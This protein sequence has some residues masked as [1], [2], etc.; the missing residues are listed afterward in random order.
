MRRFA[1]SLD[2]VWML[3]VLAGVWVFVST[4]PIRPHDFWWHIAVGRDILATGRIPEADVFS[5]TANGTPYPAYKTFWLM[6]VTLYSVYHWGGAAGVVFFQSVLITTAY[7]LLLV[8]TYRLTHSGRLAAWSVLAAALTGFGDWNVR[9]QAVTFAL[10][11]ANLLAIHAYRAR[12]HPAW[13][14]VFPLTM[15]VWVNSHGSFFIAFLLAGAW[16]ADEVWTA[17]HDLPAGRWRAPALALALMALALLS[18]PHGLGIF[19]YVLNLSQ[20][21]VVRT[22]AAEW[23]SPDPLSLFGGLFYAVMALTAVT[24]LLSPRRPAVFEVL[25][26]VG[27]GVLGAQTARGMV[28]FGLVAAPALAV[29]WAA[30]WPPQPARSPGSP[31]LNGAL[32]GL[33]LVLSLLALPWFKALWP[34]PPDKAGLIS[35]ETPLAATRF[36]LE[37]PQTQPLFNFS[38][39]GSY[40][41]WEAYPA[42]QVFVDPRFELYP[43]AVWND[44]LAIQSVQPDWETRL[45]NYGV[46]T[47]LLSPVYQPALLQAVRQSPGWREVYADAVAVIVARVQPDPAP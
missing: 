43:V 10:G 30:R 1:P 12:P 45:R 47:L 7:G 35:A 44:Y 42:Y 23:Q 38:D 20:S 4:H 17:R 21:P 46:Q 16:L 2:V 33:W 32:A 27:L 39:F 19:N 34:L 26:V 9:P 6:Q 28:W 24:W 13:L 31:W 41:I 15:L 11:A 22:L 29:H 3:A 36:L 40:L 37:N 5:V 8:L 25:T 18:S 14:A